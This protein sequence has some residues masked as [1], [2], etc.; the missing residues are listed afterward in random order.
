M[1]PQLTIRGL[2]KGSRRGNVSATANYLLQLRIDKSQREQDADNT[3][4]PIDD[5]KDNAGTQFEPF[6]V[7]DR[8]FYIQDLPPIPLKLFQVFLPVQLVAKWVKYTNEAAARLPKPEGGYQS[9][10]N[11]TTVEEVY[12]WIG[13]LIYITLY[14]EKQYKDYWRA[15]TAENLVPAHPVANF[16]AFDRFSLLKKSPMNIRSGYH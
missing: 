8:D 7:P 4:R 15:I 9:H 13:T 6:D 1:A 10:W 16:I 5:A 12:T 2:R 11:L 14:V 3:Y